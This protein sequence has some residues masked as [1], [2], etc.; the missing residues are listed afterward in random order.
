[1]LLGDV[2]SI[3]LAARTV[4]SRALDTTTVTPYD[5]LIVASSAYWSLPK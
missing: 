5:S 2:H 4:T 3:D 1:M